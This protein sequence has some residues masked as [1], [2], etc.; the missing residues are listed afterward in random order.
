[1]SNSFKSIPLAAALAAMLALA[2]AI[3][4]AQSPA[5]AHEHAAHG[6]LA[7]DHGKK[8]PTDAPLR[9]GMHNIRQLIEP[10]LR[11]VHDGKLNAEQY[12]DLARR[13]EAE[14]GHIVANCKLQP[15]A[16]AML[17][18]VIADIGAGVDALAGKDAAMRPAQGAAKIV[19]ALNDYGRYFNDAAWKPIR[20]RH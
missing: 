9:K 4:V 6:R 13:I 8:W 2:P 12:G 18:L 19:T 1:M 3:G 7:L 10:Q 14:V 15:E 16:D 20:A 17:H 11:A 5:P